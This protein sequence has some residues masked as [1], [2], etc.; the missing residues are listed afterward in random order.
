MLIN[1][2]LL[3]GFAIG[4]AIIFIVSIFAFHL[5]IGWLFEDRE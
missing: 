2:L 3:I 4:F 1:I 5:L